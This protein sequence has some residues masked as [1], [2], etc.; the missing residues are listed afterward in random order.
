ME[1]KGTIKKI[2]DPVS[3]K[4]AKGDWTRQDFIITS[5]K[6]DNDPYPDEMIVTAFGDDKISLVQSLQVGQNVTA[7]IDFK[8]REVADGKAFNSINLFRFNDGPK[9]E[10]KL[11]DPIKIDP[12]PDDI[13]W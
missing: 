9:V 11:P 12:T 2:F 10:P 1:V 5:P 8:V 7:V 6:V 3:G 4:S 13:P